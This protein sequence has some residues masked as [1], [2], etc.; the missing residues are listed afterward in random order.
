MA[1]IKCIMIII[2]I[3]ISKTV[4]HPRHFPQNIICSTSLILG[5]F[6]SQEKLPLIPSSEHSEWLDPLLGCA[7]SFHRHLNPYPL[8]KTTAKLLSYF[9]KWLQS[10]STSAQKQNTS[11]INLILHGITLQALMIIYHFMRNINSP[12]LSVAPMIRSGWSP[13]SK[14]RS[15]SSSWNANQRQ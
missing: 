5:M 11:Y 3:I 12:L 1:K 4:Q 15:L 7:A 6:I 2:T 13:L 9:I 8:S 14:P 10:Q